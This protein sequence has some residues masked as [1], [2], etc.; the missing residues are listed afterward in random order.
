M[1]VR[2]GITFGGL[3]GGD[4]GHAVHVIQTTNRIDATYIIYKA[5]RTY[6]DGHAG[7]A[8]VGLVGLHD[9][10]DAGEDGEPQHPNLQRCSF[11]G[12]GSRVEAGG[13]EPELELSKPGDPTP[14]TPT[15]NP[16]PNPATTQPPTNPPTRNHPATPS[17]YATHLRSGS[18]T[19]PGPG[20][21]T[22]TAAG[23]RPPARR[24]TSRAAPG[25]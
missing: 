18:R 8:V 17:K 7:D 21:S 22:W 11:G 9:E 16:R 25:G 14:T 19:P 4:C 13:S 23:P 10:E 24:W 3:M 2:V 1:C 6:R 12:V 15:H 5:P 20:G